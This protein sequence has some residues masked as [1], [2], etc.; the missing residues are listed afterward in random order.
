MAAPRASSFLS[1]ATASADAGNCFASSSSSLFSRVNCLPGLV[2]IGV[3]KAGTGELQNWLAAHP[4]V[5]IHGGEVHFFDGM[6]SPSA[7]RAKQRANL[8]FKYAKFLWRGRGG[9]KR[10]DVKGKLVFEKTPAYFDLAPPKLVACA[11]PSARLLVMLRE[12]AARARSAYSMCQREMGAKWCRAP[13]EEALAPL[14]KTRDDGGA[15][16]HSSSSSSNASIR[17]NRR[18][19]K[20]KPHLRRMLLMG[21]Y[22]VFLRR[23]IDAFPPARLRLLWLEQFKRDP[24]ACMRA[25]EDYVGLPNHDYRAIATRNAAGLYVVGK[26]KSS[27]AA[28][29]G[30]AAAAAAAAKKRHT[31]SSSSHSSSALAMLRQYYA[32]W[33]RRLRAL[34]AEHNLTLF[35]EGVPKRLR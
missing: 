16:D 15:L 4:S 18:L 6:K 21:H 33:Q 3:Q 10:D 34:D 24:F 11:V 5:V 25:V 20:R 23:W 28:T 26:S 30:D 2:N 13:L 29:S 35:A 31:N 8:R 22:A 17:L 32:P 9:L 7:C 27:S 19:L 12:P 1:A 14:L